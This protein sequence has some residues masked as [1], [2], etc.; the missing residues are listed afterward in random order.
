MP[1]LTVLPSPSIAELRRK[2]GASAQTSQKRRIGNAGC[3]IGRAHSAEAPWPMKGCPALASLPFTYN[4][5]KVLAG[6]CNNFPNRRNIFRPKSDPVNF[7][8]A[9]FGAKLA[10]ADEQGACLGYEHTAVLTPDHLRWPVFAWCWARAAARR[11]TQKPP[12]KAK[13][14]VRQNAIDQEPEK[15]CSET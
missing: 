6:R 14:K 2:R 7:L 8:N 12:D 9:G 1:P 4:G 13:R 15:H 3:A 5:R 10:A 11:R